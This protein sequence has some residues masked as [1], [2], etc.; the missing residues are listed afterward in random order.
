M[1]KSRHNK[2]QGL[3]PQL[4]ERYQKAHTLSNRS[5]FLSMNQLTNDKQS[6]TWGLLVPRRLT[7][8]ESLC[9]FE[10]EFTHLWNEV[11]SDSLQLR[12]LNEMPYTVQKSLSLA[13]SRYFL[14]VSKVSLP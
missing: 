3:K 14:I 1:F 13:H 7:L 8:G 9:F 11:T 5:C 10:P 2:H 4:S 6:P 12:G